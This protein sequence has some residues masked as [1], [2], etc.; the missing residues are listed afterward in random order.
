VL[1]R[2]I[3][4]QSN[5]TSVTMNNLFTWHHTSCTLQPS[6]VPLQWKFHPKLPY[7]SGRTAGS[8]PL[9]CP[10]STQ[11]PP[12]AAPCSAGMARGKT[13]VLLP[14]TDMGC[15]GEHGQ[16]SAWMSS[17]IFFRAA[18]SICTELCE[19]TSIGVHKE[20]CMKDGC[21]GEQTMWTVLEDLTGT[22]Y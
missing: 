9:P 12:A 22:V 16:D 19:N 14:L 4:N 3:R 11:P 6:F 18:F 2:H 17:R 7:Y 10:H 20:L 8:S 13:I 5:H 15:R 21:C 1:R